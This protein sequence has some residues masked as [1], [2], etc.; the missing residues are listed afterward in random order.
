MRKVKISLTNLI[1]LSIVVF[2]CVI[3]FLIGWNFITQSKKKPKVSIETGDIAPQKVEKREKIEHFEVKGEKKSKP[4]ISLKDSEI[5]AKKI[6]IFLGSKDLELKDDVK[7]T[8]K[9]QKEEERSIGFFSREEPVFITAN[10]MRYSEE[11][12]RFLFK[13]KI[14]M[15]QERK[16]LTAEELILDEETGRISC[17]GGVKSMKKRPLFSLETPS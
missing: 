14:K 3:V 12:K 17:L 8:L 5:Y 15:W 7:A 13:E 11:Q 16:T 6:L 1:R 4:R 10:K 9:L 2:L